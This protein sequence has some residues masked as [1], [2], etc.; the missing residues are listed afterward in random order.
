MKVTIIYDNSVYDE[1]L[2]SDW[3]FSALIEG[4]ATPRILFDTGKEGKILLN[5]MDRRGIQPETIDD[6]FISHDHYDHTGV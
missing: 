1:E 3:G 6:L 4:E 2:M 5:N